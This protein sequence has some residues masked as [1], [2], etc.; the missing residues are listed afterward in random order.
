V[1]A[2]GF[3]REIEEAVPAAISISPE[4][5]IIITEGN[6]LL[7]GQGGWQGVAP[8]LDETF[9]VRVD[10]DLRIERLVAR[11][12]LFGKSPEAA[13]SWATGTDERNA[14]LIE[15]SAGSATHTIALG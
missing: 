1:R 9:F 5:A 2:P 7:L 15:A 3:D 13:R 14:E 6:Y 12:A 4:F 11:H 10:H 8:L